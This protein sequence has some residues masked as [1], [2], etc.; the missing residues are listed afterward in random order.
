MKHN[1]FDNSKVKMIY[2]KQ[3]VSDLSILT[4]FSILKIGVL[5]GTEKSTK[6]EFAVCTKLILSDQVA[7]AIDNL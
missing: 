3:N 5:L 4:S 1:F 7:G 6:E 2:L